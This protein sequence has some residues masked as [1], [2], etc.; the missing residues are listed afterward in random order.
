MNAIVSTSQAAVLAPAPDAF[1]AMIER[2]SK[3]P[4][5]N[6]DKLQRLLDM[7]AQEYAQHRRDA[8]QR[9]YGGVSDRHGGHPY[10]LRK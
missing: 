2:A 7:R 4:E 9:S 10:R 1:L 6:L 3:N 8:L 5:I